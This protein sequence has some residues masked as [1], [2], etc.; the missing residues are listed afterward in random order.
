MGTKIA[1]SFRLSPEAIRLLQKLAK[2][3]GISQTAVLE[4][5]IRELARR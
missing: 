1:I 4:M 2:E 3:N 5:A